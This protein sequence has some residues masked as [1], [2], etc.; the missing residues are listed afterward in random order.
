LALFRAYSGIT[1]TV[2]G[3]IRVQSGAGQLYGVRFLN[4]SL[5]GLFLK[6]YDSTAI[7]VIGTATPIYTFRLGQNEQAP[8]QLGNPGGAG[9]QINN[10]LWVATTTNVADSDAT[11]TSGVSGLVFVWLSFKSGF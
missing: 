4:L 1:N 5:S 6:L 7:P 2:S 10:G 11:S 3:Q 9:I 8:I